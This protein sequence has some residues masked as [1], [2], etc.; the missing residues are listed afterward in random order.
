MLLDAPQSISHADSVLVGFVV[1]TS[2][3]PSPRAGSPSR[4]CLRRKLG[5]AHLRCGPCEF[6][7]H[8][9]LRCCAL[10][11]FL[12][13][14]GQHLGQSEREYAR[15]VEQLSADLP[16]IARPGLLALPA[17]EILGSWRAEF[18]LSS[19]FLWPAGTI[20]SLGLANGGL[21]KHDLTILVRRNRLGIWEPPVQPT[22][23][24]RRRLITEGDSPAVETAGSSLLLAN[25]SGASCP[26]RTVLG[27]PAF[28]PA[29]LI[30]SLR[31]G[32]DLRNQS[33]FRRACRS[34]LENPL[35]RLAEVDLDIDT[36]ERG[37]PGGSTMR[38]ARVRFD[39]AASL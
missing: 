35:S 2:W 23:R 6:L 12:P 17:R 4:L 33:H 38:Q 3:R 29:E 32:M 9:V 16:A 11:A 31:A 27:R 1:L 28:T 20:F 5:S 14:P 34:V 7:E 26:K 18:A 36:I 8:E 39:V 15:M 24:E 30:A 25:A 37:L 21:V 22:R 10:R 13:L 19:L